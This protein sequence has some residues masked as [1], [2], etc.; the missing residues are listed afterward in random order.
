MTEFPTKPPN[1]M[2]IPYNIRLADLKA[3]DAHPPRRIRR[4]SWRGALLFRRWRAR[5]PAVPPN[6]IPS[7]APGLNG[8][9]AERS[10]EL[11]E[12]GV[13]QRDIA[14][15]V[16]VVGWMDTCHFGRGCRKVRNS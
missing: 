3:A 8:Y 11:A 4:N 14:K 12:D 15:L 7:R 5:I 6:L 13:R 1:G 10:A 2:P 16:V 9:D